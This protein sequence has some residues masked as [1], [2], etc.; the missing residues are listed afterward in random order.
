M[1]I[2]VTRGITTSPEPLQRGSILLVMATR[3]ESTI[4][5]ERVALLLI[6]DAIAACSL[7]SISV[8]RPPRLPLAPAVAALVTL[9]ACASPVD[10]PASPASSIPEGAPAGAAIA[11]P[12]SEAPS[13]SS[14]PSTVLWRHEGAEIVGLV[15]SAAYY[16]D[17]EMGERGGIVSL[18]IDDGQPLAKRSIQG[19]NINGTP[20]FWLAG[21]GEEFVTSWGETPM[22]LAP[23]AGKGKGESGDLGVRWRGPTG[24][25]GDAL[26]VGDKL[27]VWDFKPRQAVV[28]FSIRTGAELWQAPLVREANGVELE[29]DG[30]SIIA[31]WQ[32]YSATAP[33]PTVTIPQRVRALEPESGASRWTRDF[34]GHTGGITVAGDT[35]L[36]AEDADLLFLEGA[37]GALIKRVATGHSP[38]IYPRFQASGQTIFVA[39]WDAVSAYDAKSGERR[40]QHPIEL[41]GGPAM[42][43]VGEHVLVSGAHELVALDRTT[44]RRAWAVSLGIRPSRLLANEHGVVAV[45]GSAVGFSLPA[46]FEPERAA[47]RGRVELR[48]VEAEAV[49]V[50]VGA[51]STKLGADG[52]YSAVVETAGLVRVS[53]MDESGEMEEQRPYFPATELVRL[54]G[55]GTYE[56][57]TMTLDRC[58]G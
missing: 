23:V 41:D 14:A 27:I 26:I 17:S 55:A 5:D 31:V 54:T 19:I 22:V 38:T 43:L 28:A 10:T 8:K 56:V 1:L 16:W 39:L 6:P 42:A 35:L 9:T 2:V 15:G 37:S 29:Y 20:S 40:W 3:A 12:G 49:T 46:H 24:R 21:Q 52:R 25:W 11:P 50:Q 47:V 45:S 30:E 57:P 32:Q 7:V 33:T 48:C 4:G 44:G 13:P 36:V 34:K 51:A 53:A 18:G 58:Q